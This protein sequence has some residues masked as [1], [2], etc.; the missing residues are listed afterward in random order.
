M[1]HS[2]HTQSCAVIWLEHI[3]GLPTTVRELVDGVLSAAA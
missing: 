3:G 2:P 1:G